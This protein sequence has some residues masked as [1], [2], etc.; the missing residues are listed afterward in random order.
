MNLKLKYFIK[1]RIK[2]ERTGNRL[3]VSLV[4]Q[5]KGNINGFSSGR[6][7]LTLGGL[8][9]EAGKK[10]LSTMKMVNMGVNLNKY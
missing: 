9:K 5:T 2:R 3:I 8:V 1:Q 10:K 7:I 4:D 6:R